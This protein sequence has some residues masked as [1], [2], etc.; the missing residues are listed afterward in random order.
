MKI[1]DTG[2]PEVKII[3]PA[4][5][6]DARGFFTELFHKEKYSPVTELDFVQDNMSYS[7]YGTLRGLHLQNPN[8]QGKL[9]QCLQG[10]VLD[11]AVDVRVG[12]PNF[13]KSVAVELSEFDHRQLYIP[14]GFAHGFF[15]TSVHAL[16]M[17]KYTA[18]YSP[19]HDMS[20]AWNDP[21]L[22]IDWLKGKMI[23]PL[24]SLKD[25]KA[26]RLRDI[27]VGELPKY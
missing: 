23:K 4:F 7:G 17:Y 10:C 25:S 13:G 16:F 11:V 1:I 15:V 26:R 27:P 2:L 8:P 6:S 5:F 19:E 9:V 24:V 3:E 22:D 18:L 12:S 14:P 21:D 20:I